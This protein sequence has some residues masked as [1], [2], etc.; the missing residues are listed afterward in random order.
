V[1]VPFRGSADAALPA[2]PKVDQAA[3]PAG[4]AQRVVM[5]GRDQF[6]RV[7]AGHGQQSRLGPQTLAQKLVRVGVAAAWSAGMT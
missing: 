5:A 2:S 4:A 3:G 1:C 7:A 6:R